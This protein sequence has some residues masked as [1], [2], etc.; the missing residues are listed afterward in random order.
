MTAR[1]RFRVRSIEWNR[2]HYQYVVQH[3]AV[4]EAELEAETGHYDWLPCS[5][6]ARIPR[7]RNYKTQA[8]FC[9][10]ACRAVLED[11]VVDGIRSVVRWVN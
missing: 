10:D 5:C 9:S 6:G 3:R 11:D 1:E 8:Y 2:A 7:T 4:V